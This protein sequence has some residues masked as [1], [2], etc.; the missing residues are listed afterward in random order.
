MV[1]IPS[2]VLLGADGP[3]VASGGASHW[4]DEDVADGDRERESHC[5]EREH[6]VEEREHGELGHGEVL[7][8]I[9]GGFGEDGEGC[10]MWVAMVRNCSELG[11]QKA[12]RRIA[13]EGRGESPG[14]YTFSLAERLIGPQTDRRLHRDWWRKRHDFAHVLVERCTQ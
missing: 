3:D 12:K 14:I 9:M 10:V 5:E 1:N 8:R 4:G 13:G 7:E 6:D 2:N 11:G